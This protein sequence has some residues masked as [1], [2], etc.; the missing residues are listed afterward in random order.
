MR[1]RISRVGW[2]LHLRG[3]LLLLLLLEAS[4]VDFAQTLAGRCDLALNRA[5]HLRGQAWSR[6]CARLG[7]LRRG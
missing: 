4:L 6:E 3:E 1:L 2:L 7:G 5:S